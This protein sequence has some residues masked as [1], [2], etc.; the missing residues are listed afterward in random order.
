MIMTIRSLIN[1]K[2][3]TF[4]LNL[5]RVKELTDKKGDMRVFRNSV[6]LMFRCDVLAITHYI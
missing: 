6:E 5:E 1:G 4:K 2:V 3:S